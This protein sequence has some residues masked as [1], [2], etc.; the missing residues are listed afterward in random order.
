MPYEI[1]W[2]VLAVFLYI[3]CAMLL[4]IEIFVPSFGLLTVIS[5]FCLAGGVAL[6]FQMGTTVGWIGVG[7][8]LVLI[9]AVWIIVY[10]MFPH[11]SMGKKLILQKVVRARGDAIQDQDQLQQMINRTGVV[12]TPLRPVGMCEFDGQKLECVS[13]SGYIP[14]NVKVKII[15][16]EGTQLTVRA[17]DPQD[18]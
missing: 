1:L 9:P 14:A 4:V 11:T 15:H 5:L 3:L 12:V 13:E 6:F 18:V 10:K 2:I 17:M 7:V 8:A 16:I